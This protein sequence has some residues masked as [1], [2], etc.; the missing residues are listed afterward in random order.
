MH[1]YSYA[2]I[3]FYVQIEYKV[4]KVSLIGLSIVI[5][6]REVA[7]RGFQAK[8]FISKKCSWNKV[9]VIK[10]EENRMEHKT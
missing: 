9:N 8:V 3:Y 1:D 7:S 5:E 10:N 2:R 6:Y 4:Q